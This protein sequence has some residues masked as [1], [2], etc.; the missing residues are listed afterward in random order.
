MD[1]CD[2]IY[3]GSVI[4]AE[5]LSGTVEAY[6]VSYSGCS[7]AVIPETA[8]TPETVAAVL[9]A[10]S[11]GL[12]VIIAQD[13]RYPISYEH[14]SQ[15]LDFCH[16]L[17]QGKCISSVYIENS[18]EV[19]DT[20][21]W[22]A[23]IGY[24]CKIEIA[25][26]QQKADLAIVSLRSVANGSIRLSDHKYVI[27]SGT[28]QVEFDLFNKSDTFWLNFY[29]FPYCFCV[30]YAKKSTVCGKTDIF[31]Q[32]K[33][34]MGFSVFVADQLGNNVPANVTGNLMQSCKGSEYSTPFRAVFT[35]DAMLFADGIVDGYACVS[36]RLLRTSDIRN[37]LLECER[38]TDCAV[39]NNM[40]F[41]VTDVAFTESDIRSVI[42][43]ISCA[44][45]FKLRKAP[46]IPRT[47]S[48]ATD[49]K[50]LANLTDGIYRIC[51]AIE[52]S[53][54]SECNE[55]FNIDVIYAEKPEINIYCSENADIIA[56][57]AVRASEGY[58]VRLFNTQNPDTA[59]VFT[60][61]LTD[62]QKQLAEIWKSVLG[63]D[64]LDIDDDFFK[65][66]GTSMLL[67]KLAFEISDALGID[68]QIQD[69]ML[70]GTVRK[71][72]DHIAS[73]S[74]RDTFD[75]KLKM[76]SEDI[77]CSI[78][79]E[80]KLN[81]ITSSDN[82]GILVIGEPDQRCL[83]VVSELLKV[84][85]DIVFMTQSSSAAV[86]RAMEELQLNCSTESIRAVN[87]DITKPD[88]GLTRE[89]Y[90]E[91]A[92]SIKTVY[93]FGL[94]LNL[95]ASYE[96]LR[97]KNISGTENVIS[98]CCDVSSKKLIFISSL[99]ALKATTRKKL[100]VSAENTLITPDM[101]QK[102]SNK[103][104]IYSAYAADKLVQDA[105]SRGIDAVILRVPRIMGETV[106]GK[107]NTQDVIWTIIRYLINKK[108]SPEV[109]IMQ[110]FILPA[111]ILAKQIIGIAS[112]NDTG[113]FIYN[114]KGIESQASDI[115]D[116]VNS[117]FTGLRHITMKEWT[118]LVRT[119]NSYA[120]NTVIPMLG[121]LSI[122]PDEDTD[123]SAV[124]D[125]LTLDILRSNNI[126]TYEG[127]TLNEIMDTTYK[128]L[129][130]IGFFK[131]R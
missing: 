87:G 24:D 79:I 42:N 17:F 21:V 116:W 121:H 12:P 96:A 83:T 53:I 26:K 124:S 14:L 28:E 128:Y 105:Y 102:Y 5:E 113:T 45:K 58:T 6:K 115:I 1:I 47:S 63:I 101:L 10:Y 2:L 48:G 59:T 37:T 131:E 129:E 107:F 38:I 81:G 82:D 76:I 23:G 110:E 34:V 127:H 78:D 3:N 4:S 86:F 20:L 114:L 112:L 93:N 68:L 7:E 60:S 54:K 43:N 35:S 62:L 92:G 22:L 15:W 31:H 55:D 122:I 109:Y 30:S 8:K 71:L 70:Y 88:F 126:C 65:L 27:T 67:I 61:E 117:N 103:E 18:P 120:D 13:K 51:S 25:D 49:T 85:A 111:D 89:E 73:Q 91:L 52:S 100:A 77:K 46:Y 44:D 32:L 41:Y 64:V 74:V 72:A 16:K 40:I 66:G 97:E 84:S 123:S 99:A 39:I 108:L 98:F 118:E 130:S 119:D 69:V 11:S 50:Q 57:V 29:G 75:Q 104:Y 106:T 95:S 19:I 36:G 56:K 80:K 90:K 9:A 33:P 125:E 94:D